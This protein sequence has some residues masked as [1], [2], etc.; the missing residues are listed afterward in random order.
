[1]KL[2]ENIKYMQETKVGIATSTPSRFMQLLDADAM[3]ATD[4]R[5]IVVDGSH[6]DSKR[7]TIFTL[8]QVF[9][10]LIALL[11]NKVIRPR[12]GSAEDKIEIL[13]F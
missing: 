12:Y 1:M 9:Q 2:K 10:P 11:N 3:K 4:L 6:R 5:R 7:S 8:G 13:V